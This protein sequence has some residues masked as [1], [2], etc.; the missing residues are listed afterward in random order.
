MTD[1]TMQILELFSQPAFL[2]K[3]E[4]V[5]WCN[6][7]ARPLVEMGTPIAEI[8][9]DRDTLLSQWSREGV[10]QISVMM[11]GRLFDASVKTHDEY[12][13]FVLSERS[14]MLEASA[15][16]VLNASTSLRKPLH[17][18]LN[19]AN[20]LFEK[21]D[22][23]EAKD[24]ASQVNRAI[25]QLVRLCGQMSDGSRLLLQ[26]MQVHRRPADI[27]KFFDQFV[28][29]VRPLIEASGRSL[30]YTPVQAGIRADI[31]AALIERAILN[32]ISNA[33]AY[34]SA[35]GSLTFRLTVQDKHLLIA[36]SDDGE[37]IAPEVISSIFERHTQ[38]AGGDS[39]WGLGYGLPMVRQIA[40][41][42]GGSMMIT[43]NM[44]GSGTTAVLS[45]SLEPTALNLHSPIVAYDYCSGLNHALVEL[46]DTLGKELYDPRE[47]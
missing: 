9:E 27:R 4:A 11:R 3:D 14:E 31:D 12:L 30:R 19:A 29:Q 10:A 35:G 24:T 37:G 20:S 47:I 1:R 18:L 34:T 38:Q 41:E 42:H 7:A 5:A 36:L 23:S 45:V 39:R 2:V 40:H 44:S 25:Y 8:M 21:I 15:S 46:S 16:A 43:A 6:A 13:L 17:T 26:K 22:I 32:L 28:Q 33:L